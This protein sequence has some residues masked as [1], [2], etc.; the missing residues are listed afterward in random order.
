VLTRS[1]ETGEND[2]S[3]EMRIRAGKLNLVDLAGSE[4]QSKTKAE[5]RANSLQFSELA[6]FLG[7]R[8]FASQCL[9]FLFPRAVSRVLSPV[10]TSD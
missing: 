1:V 9:A 8:K 3:G 4:R 2:E 5:V 7:C 6:S 10:G